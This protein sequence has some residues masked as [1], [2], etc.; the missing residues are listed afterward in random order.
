[1][2]SLEQ[3]LTVHNGEAFSL[4]NAVPV[5]MDRFRNETIQSVTAG[6]RIA[7]LTARPIGDSRFNLTAVVAHD[8]ESTL[9]IFTTVVE[10]E[11]ASITP[12]CPQ[13]HCFEREIFE[14]CSLMPVGHPWLKPIRFPHN[15]PAHGRENESLGQSV[16]CGSTDFFRMEGEE[17][18][19]VAVGPVHAGIIEPGHFRFQCH[20]ETVYHLEI[21]LGYQ[22]RGVERALIGG[23][24]QRSIHYIETL[25]GDTS[26]GHAIAYCR[27]VEAISQTHVSARAQVI[28]GIAL[29]LERIAN[30]IGDLGALSGD[31]GYLPTMSYCGRIRGD[32]LNMTAL[33]C[34]NR[35]GRNL[36]RPGGVMYDLD[37]QM[38]AELKRRA[39]IVAKDAKVS[40]ELLWESPSVTA[41]FDQTGALTR[42][43]CNSIGLVGIAARACGIPRDVRQDFPWGIYRFAQ[44]P[45]STW[46]SGDVFARAYV[47][48][49]EIQRS[50][51]FIDEQLDSLPEGPILETPGPIRPDYSVVTL[52]E[53]WRGE[54]CHIAAT[55]AYGNWEHYKVVDPSFHNW[56]G[57]G[58]A[59]R[60]QQISDFPLCNK[61]FNLSYCGHDL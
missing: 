39:D 23:P 41:R 55:D 35:F 21:S 54:I 7:S 1:M 20:G 12:Q 26:V 50:L 59:L 43:V 18:H 37:Q 46:H 52:A 11:Y 40:V 4:A 10:R 24:N 33:L 34:G 9:Q 14:Q 22:H 16:A 13:A 48:W 8:A 25:A 58:L 27:A 49:L 53:G 3:S 51:A 61:S 36:I 17:V 29:E 60:N 42:E 6:G 31:V 56:F 2:M 15:A 5:T 38:I 57:L 28:R 47:R 30:H 45:V 32:V 19:E 44:I